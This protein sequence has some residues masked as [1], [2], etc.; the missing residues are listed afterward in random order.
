MKKA[1]LYLLIT[2]F[3]P[4]CTQLTRGVFVPSE[5]EQYCRR[6]LGNSNNPNAM[7][8][9]IQQEYSAKNEISRMAI[10]ADIERRCRL[11][12]ISTGG[13]YQVMLTCV[14]NELRDRAPAE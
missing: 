14:Q 11:L 5:I 1:L 8:T 7:N 13:S 12:S 9:C 6:I 10:P 3:L 2:V 4:G